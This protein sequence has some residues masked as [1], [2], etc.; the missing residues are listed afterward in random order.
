MRTAQAGAATDAGVT[1]TVIDGSALYTLVG[2]ADG[3]HP[4]APQQAVYGPAERAG[5]GTW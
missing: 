2:S 3:L 1:A 5:M 4:A